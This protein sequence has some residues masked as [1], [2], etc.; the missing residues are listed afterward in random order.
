MCERESTHM[1]IHMWASECSACRGQSGHQLPWSW[2]CG[3]LWA[4][5]QMLATKAAPL[6]EQ[7]M[8]ALARS[9]WFWFCLCVC[10]ICVW[11]KHSCVC[12]CT[13]LWTPDISLQCH[14]SGMVHLVALRP[15]LSLGTEA[16]V[17]GQAVWA[18]SSEK[19]HPPSPPISLSPNPRIT[20]V[21]PHVQLFV[22][23]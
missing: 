15:G 4:T 10:V 23:F 14:A 8:P 12:R 9:H 13:C 20:G 19:S 16:C 6:Q 5:Q 21:F 17:L 1:W 18:E 11:W 22:L 2:N 7:H 3:W